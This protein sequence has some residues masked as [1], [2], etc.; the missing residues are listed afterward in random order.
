MHL[1]QPKLCT[2][3]TGL[4]VE[5]KLDLAFHSGLQMAESNELLQP[6]LCTRRTGLPVEMK[7]DLAF[8]SGLQMADSNGGD[9]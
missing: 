4:P 2:R 8:H 9:N 7:L 6:K 3:K 5:M 1:L